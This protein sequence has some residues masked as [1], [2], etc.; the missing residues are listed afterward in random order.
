MKKRSMDYAVALLVFGIGTL[1]AQDIKISDF[2][3]PE[4]KA[5]RLTGNLTSNAYRSASEN[6]SDSFLS[7]SFRQDDDLF[8]S[9]SANG[10]VFYNRLAIGEESSDELFGNF[11]LGWDYDYSEQEMTSSPPERTRKNRS[12]RDG[13]NLWLTLDWTGRYY[14]ESDTW[15]LFGSGRFDADYF[16]SER[17]SKITDSTQ[18]YEVSSFSRT[19]GYSARLSGGLGYGKVRDGTNVFVVLRIL[20]NLKAD[21]ML[22]RELNHQEILRLVAMYSRISEYRM[23]Q[24]RFLKFF[25]SDLMK[26]LE[27]MEALGKRNVDS[28]STL[29]A[30]EVLSERIQLRLF[31]WR[32][33]GGIQHQSSQHKRIYP[34][35]STFDKAAL[36]YAVAE[37]EYGVDLSLWSHARAFVSARVPLAP[38]KDRRFSLDVMSSY[39]YELS[40]R[41]EFIGSFRSAVLNDD[42]Y[43]SLSLGVFRKEITHSITGTLYFFIENSVNFLL[44]AGYGHRTVHQSSGSST[45]RIADTSLF[46]SAG[47]TYRFF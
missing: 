19:Y 28:Y 6:R 47:I 7:G 4:T 1:Q 30:L 5:T 12:R 10:Q 43:Y 18:Y 26:V 35:L 16:L 25:F 45:L 34:G 9:G 14:W 42:S 11:G 41:I 27:E 37:A 31:G 20:E 40:E 22:V 3:I 29:R 24:D 17:F 2:R 33:Q 44:G 32:V 46:A 8:L 15:Y 21:G 36:D 38:G 23:T 39:T 13:G